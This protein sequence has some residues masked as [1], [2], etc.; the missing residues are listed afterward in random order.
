MFKV[1]PPPAS[2]AIAGDAT[3]IIAQ[4]IIPMRTT[5]ATVLVSFKLELISK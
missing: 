2:C 5:F 3:N 1:N 4:H